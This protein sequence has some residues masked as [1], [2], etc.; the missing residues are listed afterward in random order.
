MRTTASFALLA[1]ASFSLAACGS[2]RVATEGQTTTSTVRSSSAATSAVTTPAPKPGS[3]VDGAELS[4]EL[5]AK[6]AAAKS[7]QSRTNLGDKGGPATFT[8]HR[9]GPERTDFS[10]VDERQEGRRVDGTLFLKGGRGRP[11]GKWTTADKHDTF[12]EPRGGDFVRTM[13]LASGELENDAIA[14]G[15]STTYVSVDSA[16]QHY[17]S[18][19]PATLFMR[20][21]D[22]HMRKGTGVSGSPEDDGASSERGRYATATVYIDVWVGADGRP[23]RYAVDGNELARIDGDSS[24]P[25]VATIMLSQWDA[26]VNI[27]A[28]SIAP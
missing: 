24:G 14:E 3:V 19:V 9:F 8:F 6:L 21:L 20:L 26:P 22:E 2:E 7:Y 27:V 5:T 18:A 16:G 11:A 10:G 1:A 15:S 23:V 12:G 28:P 25:N 17:R 13:S 4:K